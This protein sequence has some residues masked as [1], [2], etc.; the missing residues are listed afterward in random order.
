MQNLLYVISVL[1]NSLI[2][3][4]ALFSYFFP[5]KRIW[6]PPGGDSWQFYLTWTL[7]Y[8]GMF[9]TP[10]LGILDWGTLYPFSFESTIF[11]LI[12]IIIGLTFALWAVKTLSIHQSQGLKG[13]LVIKGPYRYSRNPQYVGFILFY[14]GV[15]L[16]TTSKMSL[17]TSCLVILGFLVAP[18]SEELWLLERFGDEYKEY[19]E[20]V[21]RFL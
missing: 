4:G 14:L 9:S 12:F 7:V 5:E 18:L 6:P 19:L 16:I 3:V 2:I 11:G 1:S 8:I 10:I 15:I 20:N 21:R 17:V 13:R